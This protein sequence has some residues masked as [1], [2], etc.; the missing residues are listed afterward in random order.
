M[1]VTMMV[2]LV[3]DFDDEALDGDLDPR[4][5]ILNGKVK[6][7]KANMKLTDTETKELIYEGDVTEEIKDVIESK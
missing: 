5:M 3:L 7:L 2:G 4:E 6:V 1:K